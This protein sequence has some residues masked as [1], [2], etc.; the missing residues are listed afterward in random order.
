MLKFASEKKKMDIHLL[1]N[2]VGVMKRK[3]WKKEIWIDRRSF[4]KNPLILSKISSRKKITLLSK[5]FRNT[6]KI[7]LNSYISKFF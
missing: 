5:D 4:E 6:L 2:M 1:Q 7:S 3:E